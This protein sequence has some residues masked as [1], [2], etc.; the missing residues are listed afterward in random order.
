MECHF[1]APADEEFEY[2]T[3]TKLFSEEREAGDTFQFY[4][5]RLRN[6]I[7]QTAVAFRVTTFESYAELKVGERPVLSGEIDTGD[8]MFLSEQAA[9]FIDPRVWADVTTVQELSVFYIG[10]KIPIP[11]AGGCTVTL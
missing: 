4:V 5:A 11:V 8:A 9:K 6:P 3:L 7:S 10:F 1:Y 2:I